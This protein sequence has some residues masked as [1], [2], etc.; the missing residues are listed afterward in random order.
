MAAMTTIPQEVEEFRMALAARTRNA[1]VTTVLVA[2]NI[3][4]LAAMTVKGLDPWSAGADDLVEWGA[5]Y[6]PRNTRGEWWRLLT[7]TFL[8]SGAP[9]LTL[10][11]LALMQIGPVVERLLGNRAFAVVYL[12]AGIFASVTSI[13]WHPYTVSVGASGALFGI[14]GVWVAYLLRYRDT[15]PPSVRH[16]LQRRAAILIALNLVLGLLIKNIAMA[17]HVGGLFAGVGAGL[18][19]ARPLA[20]HRVR[21]SRELVTLAIGLVLVVGTSAMLPRPFDLRSEVANWQLAEDDN[22]RN[23]NGAVRKRQA[24]E[25][26]YADLAKVIDEQV[27]PFWNA[28]ARRLTGL[29]RLSGEYRE[30]VSKK[31]AY[32]ALRERAWSKLSEALRA[33]D[34]R[35]AVE[36]TTLHEKADAIVQAETRDKW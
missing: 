14:F 27:L 5:N 23:Y 20:E 11:I 29:P 7:S 13:A 4:V 36:A 28:R 8:H 18:L 34:R 1:W 10:N 22:L 21:I 17:A 30:W 3:T 16:T 9:H 24:S 6:A 2:I 19:L 35:K 15:I 33:Q 32:V 31:L 12:M 25:I 26:S